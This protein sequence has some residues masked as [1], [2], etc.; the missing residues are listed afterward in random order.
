MTEIKAISS[1]P[2][3]AI[4]QSFIY[5][6]D[7]LVIR[8][9]YIDQTSVDS[10]INRLEDCFSSLVSEF[11]GYLEKSISDSEKALYSVEILMLEDQEYHKSIHKLISEKLYSAP[12][13]VEEA[14]EQIIKV[15][16]TVEDE[17]LKERIVDIRD[18]EYAVLETLVGKRRDHITINDECIFVADYILTSELLGL[19]G[20]DSIKGIVLDTGGKTSH[21]SILAKSKNIPAVVGANGFSSLISE[22]D[23]VVVDA[24][25]GKAIAGASR[26]VLSL[27]RNKIE[28][29][30]RMLGGISPVLDVKGSTKDGKRLVLDANIEWLEGVDDAIRLGCE[31]IGLFRT[32]FIAIRDDIANERDKKDEIYEEA[33]RRMAGRG[34]IVFRTLDIGGDKKTDFMADEENPILGWRAVRYMLSHKDDFKAQ[35]AA[36]LKASKYRN[37]RM[38]FPMISGVEE[39]DECLA[40]LEEVKNDLR[41]KRIEFD[42]EMKVG[43]MIEIPSAAL[44][45]D[46]LAKKVDFFSI[47]TNDLIQYTI[48][49]DRGNDKTNYLYNPLHPG[50]IR[51]IKYVVDN[52]HENSIE[53]GLCGQMASEPEYLPLLIGLGLDEI[54]M[55]PQSIP[56]VK[57]LLLSLSYSDC[58]DFVNEVLSKSSHIEIEKLLKEFLYERKTG[59][60]E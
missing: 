20:L 35:M 11:R 18:I 3:Y 50:I 37:V 5:R 4:G 52:A 19:K 36:I 32:E 53:V 44:T 56:V 59:N 38:M 55:S 1:S 47:G 41:K 14:T 7:K 12:W 51:L 2:G 17:Y 33:A 26:K 40:L 49:V 31:N 15:I 46:I 13:A 25:E 9:D 28:E 57:P 34:H 22:G 58:L 6:H 48:A 24:M 42:E 54:S 16:S 45:S 27:Y 43:T 23:T 30:E 39:L 29:R 60:K 8:H 21:V 10:E